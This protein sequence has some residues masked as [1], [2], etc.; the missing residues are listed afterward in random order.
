MSDDNGRKGT[1]SSLIGGLASK[2]SGEKP[3]PEP[4]KDAAKPPTTY[5]YEPK[6]SGGILNAMLGR[7]S[8]QAESKPSIQSVPQSGETKSE[9]GKRGILAELTHRMM[10]TP[11]S[12]PQPTNVNQQPANSESAMSDTPNAHGGRYG[13]TYDSAS[14]Y[15]QAQ[16]ED[17]SAERGD[18]DPNLHTR[19]PNSGED[20]DDD[21]YA[22]DTSADEDLE[23]TS[24]GF[25]VLSENAIIL[26]D[27]IT[28]DDVDADP[29]EFSDVIGVV[30]RYHPEISS[31]HD[32]VEYI[33]NYPYDDNELFNMLRADF[34]DTVDKDIVEVT[35]RLDYTFPEQE[36]V[37]QHLHDEGNEGHPL[38][39]EE[40]KQIII[41]LGPEH[42]DDFAPEVLDCVYDMANVYDDVL[43]NAIDAVTQ[44]WIDDTVAAI[45]SGEV[46]ND[47]VVSSLADPSKLDDR[48]DIGC[49]NDVVPDYMIAWCPFIRAGKSMYD[50]PI[51]KDS[52]TMC[53]VEMDL[54]PS[55]VADCY[56]SVDYLLK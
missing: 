21:D 55:D 34:D 18:D 6:R 36:A 52:P 3:S 46:P 1:L 33:Y 4:S 43:P 45:D 20:G 23:I 24:S 17:E 8:E 9:S 51:R 14:Q 37:V 44:D 42:I 30:K 53:P 40:I 10:G 56:R 54:A 11:S 29:V 2:A 26:C 39:D 35:R 27:W 38:E 32:A 41:D 16:R 5:G 15:D 49:M 7:R 28:V 19:M 48:L 22:W 13:G 25:Y 50:C 47:L 12:K 31:P